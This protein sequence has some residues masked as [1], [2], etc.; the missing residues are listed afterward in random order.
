MNLLKLSWKNLTHRPLNTLL[1]LLLF[2]LGVGLITFLFLLNTQVQEKFDKNLAEIDLVLGAKGS[3]LQMILSSMYHIDAPT[4]NI[5]IDEA[6]AFLREG[7]PL[8]KQAIPLS[9][10]DNYKG[11]RI[12]GTTHDLPALYEAEVAEGRLWSKVFEVTIGAAVA[13]EHGLKLGDKFKSSH[14]FVVDDNLVH[15]DAESFVVS[16]IFAPSGSVVDQ[17]IL[18]NTQSI[19]D[20]HGSHDH[21]HD[22][23]GHDHDHDHDEAAHDHDE[24]GHDHDHDHGEAGHD[25]DHAHGSGQTNSAEQIAFLLDHPEEEIT[26]MLLK[27]KARNYQTL[28]FARN[29]NE[30][31]DLM[32]SVPAIEINRVYSRL[33]VGMDALQ[34]L[35][36]VIVF[37]SGLSIFISLYSSLKQRRYELALIRVMGGSR[38]TLFLLI[39]LEGILLAVI[40]YIIGEVLSHL[41]METLAGYMKESYR[42]TFSGMQFL[43]EELYVLVGALAI[44]LLAAIL[45]AIGA[46]R[47]DISTTLAR[48]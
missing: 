15:G 2:A 11:Y 24:A 21:D 45:P 27:F 42:Y 13:E 26:S 3:P 18:T 12:V 36:Y 4:G 38:A 29:I 30:N 32:A 8:I 46:A 17:L 10:G 39:I 9:L 43:R 19:W 48:G 20:V 40:G 14:G 1:S 35:A 7:H 5:T 6:K 31:T 47:T 44:G 41:A 23:A 16:G 34:V 25:H 22:E 28:N 33:G 37:V